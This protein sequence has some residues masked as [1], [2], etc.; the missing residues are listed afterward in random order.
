[1][2][3]REDIPEN[4]I[5]IYTDALKVAYSDGSISD[6][7]EL[8]MESLRSRFEIENELHEELQMEVFAYLAELHKE[9]GE[10]EEALKW[11]QILT[12]IDDDDEFAWRQVGIIY[13]QK[14]DYQKAGKALRRAHQISER[15]KKDLEYADKVDKKLEFYKRM[16]AEKD[17]AQKKRKEREKKRKRRYREPEIV[18]EVP[19]MI[20]DEPVVI[21]EGDS[22]DVFEEEPSV[23]FDMEP[24]E[25]PEIEIEM[26]EE[27]EEEEEPRRRSRREGRKRRREKSK[28]PEPEAPPEE[29]DEEPVKR[30]PGGRRRRSREPTPPPEE[31]E[32]EE[33]PARPR[34]GRRRRRNEEAEDEKKGEEAKPRRREG[35]RRRRDA[36][37]DKKKEEEKKDS[38]KC[39]KCKSKVI[40]PSKKRPIVIK[41]EKC[42]ASGKLTK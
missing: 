32:E 6:D 38:M 35:G 7:G 10:E 28:A 11:Y 8:M 30:R 3:K 15:A 5:R 17:E 18:E 13:T 20:E 9:K 19:E 34:E 22:F 14:N 42:G 37:A 1:M 4:S 23:E 24:P 39:P 41:C 27:E 31:K 21:M 25:E 33:K 40:I 12:E 16:Q 2:A 29:P 26:E 36:P